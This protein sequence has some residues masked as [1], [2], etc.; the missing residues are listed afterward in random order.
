MA[1]AC[2]Q[3]EFVWIRSTDVLSRQTIDDLVHCLPVSVTRDSADFNHQPNEVD[4]EANDEPTQQ[5][6]DDKLYDAL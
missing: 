3:F 6:R 5:K 1:P 4:D 2:D